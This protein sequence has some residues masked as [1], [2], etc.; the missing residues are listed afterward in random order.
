VF[1]AF[2][3]GVGQSKTEGVTQG[4][5]KE[6]VSAFA[7]P[8]PNKKPLK[9]MQIT[10]YKAKTSRPDRDKAAHKTGFAPLNLLKIV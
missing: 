6:T 8:S 10:A 3:F 5:T 2:E 1:H 7:K 9:D 4:L